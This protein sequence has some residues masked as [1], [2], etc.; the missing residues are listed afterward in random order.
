[1]SGDSYM[2]PMD[3]LMSRGMDFRKVP[4]VRHSRYVLTI[5]GSSRF[6][7]VHAAVLRK[8][9]LCGVIA[10]PMGLMGHAEGLDMD[11]PVKK[12]LDDLHLDKIDMSDGI[13]VVNQGG[14]IGHSTANEIAYAS[15]RG[16]D[17]YY[18]E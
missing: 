17:I 16:K 1:M 10:I 6:G 5:C 2:R 11:G 13:F 15:S 14:Y 12:M 8:L 9:T 18:L 7:M 3:F 4:R